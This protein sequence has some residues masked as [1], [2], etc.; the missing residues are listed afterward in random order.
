MLAIIITMKSII[1]T[2]IKT[3]PNG[4]ISIPCCRFRCSHF[5]EED[6]EAQ[7]DGGKSQD[8]PAGKWDSGP[9]HLTP[10]ASCSSLTLGSVTECHSRRQT[11]PGL[12]G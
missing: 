1:I 7:R 3:S 9:D 11:G 4:Y 6:A 2:V 10:K 12:D 5:T 8:Q